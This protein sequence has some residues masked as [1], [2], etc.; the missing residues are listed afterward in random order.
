M[1]NTLQRS[2]LVVLPI[3]NMLVD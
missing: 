1:N 2:F 3:K